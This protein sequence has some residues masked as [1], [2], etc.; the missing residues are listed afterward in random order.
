MNTKTFTPSLGAPGAGEPLTV[1]ATGD[2]AG[3]YPG[4]YQVSTLIVNSQPDIFLYLG[5]V[6]ER[7]TPTE[8]H[9]WYGLR[10]NLYGRLRDITNPTVGNHEYLTTSAAGYFDYRDNIPHYYSYNTG[11]WHFIS[12]DLTETYNQVAPST[13]QYQWLENDLRTNTLPCVAAYFHHPRYSIGPQGDTAREAQVWALLAQYGVDVVLTG[14]DHSYQRWVP[15]DGSGNPAAQGITEFVVGTGGYGT[16]GFVRSD[17]RVAATSTVY[18]AWYGDL[19]ADRMEYRY[20]NL[21]N[22]VLDAGTVPCSAP[23]LPP[24]NTPTSTPTGTPYAY[25]HRDQHAYADRHGDQYADQY[26][27][28]HPHR[29]GDQY[30]NRYAYQHPHRYIDRHTDPYTDRHTDQYAYEHAHAGSRA[31]DDLWAGGR[32]VCLFGES[33]DKLWAPGQAAG[34]WI[35]RYAELPAV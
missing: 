35:A 20:V 10:D 32:R 12:L 18:G 33:H 31:G 2:G 8:Y 5:D 26:A 22:Q 16:Q 25:Q 6:Y 4:N 30:T 21:A 28:Q 14:H 23:A 27:Y 15:L 9:N 3:S 11:G 17:A 19:Y 24:T 1:A 13:A 7:G 29:H 34:R